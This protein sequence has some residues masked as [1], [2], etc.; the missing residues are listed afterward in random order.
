M[1]VRILTVATLLASAALSP[2]AAQA[3]PS[4]AG[5]W[6]VNTEKSDPMGGGMGGGGGGGGGGMGGMMGS[7]VT[8]ITQTD[9]KL[10]LETKMGENTR[11][12]TY[13]LDG[14]ESTNTTPR[15][16]S[17]S[18]VH[19]DG[20]SLVIETTSSFNGPNGAMTTTSKEVRTLSP[21]AKIMTVVR[22]SQGPNGETT[23]K[24]VYDKQ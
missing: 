11:T 12:S 7:M 15:G 13:N 23:R 10:V 5:S 24:T 18:K 8:T 16:E 20:A 4:F 3:K 21:D 9:T 19:W 2:L 1:S 14:T 6:K 17:K 22:T